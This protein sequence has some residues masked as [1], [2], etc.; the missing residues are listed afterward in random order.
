LPVRKI[1]HCLVYITITIIVLDKITLFLM[2]LSYQVNGQGNRFSFVIIKKTVCTYG[3]I[4]KLFDYRY[5]AF[6]AFKIIGLD[7][8]HKDMAA[9]D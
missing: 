1:F 6:Q 3:I 9:F 4:L 5:I 2:I 8:L 7:G